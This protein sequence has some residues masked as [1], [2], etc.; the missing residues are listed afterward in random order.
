MNSAIKTSY[1]QTLVWMVWLVVFP[2]A[3]L[4]P[5][6]M[7]VDVPPREELLGIVTLD[8]SLGNLFP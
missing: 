5:F 3:L 8:E 1:K 6:G 4:G 7:G 2:V